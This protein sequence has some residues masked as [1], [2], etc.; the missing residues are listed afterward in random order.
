MLALL[1][2]AVSLGQEPAPPVLSHGP[3][4]GPNGP[5]S[6]S[7]WARADRPGEYRLE[8]THAADGS[9]T[10]WQAQ[11]E[12]RTDLTLHWQATGLPAGAAFTA[13]VYRGEQV[14]F[15]DRSWVLTTAPKEPAAAAV[16]AFGSCSNDKLFPEQP[17]WG[18]VLARAPQ[19]LV[20]LGD[21]P[22]IDLGTLPA[23]RQRFREFYALPSVRAALQTVPTW[24]TWDDHDFATNDAFGAAKGSDTA[25]QVFAEYHADARL[26]DGREGIYTSFR[27]GP[28]EVFLLDTRSFADTGPS[29]FA[30]EA[31]TLLGPAQSAWLQAGLRQSL[32]PFKVLACG[33]VWN[34]AVRPKKLDCWANWSD[35]RDALWR[36]L[37]S[38]GIGGVVLVSGDVHRSRVLRHA[39]HTSVGYELLEFVTSPLAQNPIA[40][41]A[42][43]VPG[44]EFDAAEPH[45]ALLLHAT[46][47]GAA[48]QLQA[49]FVAGDGREFHHR[50]V[51]RRDL[52][53]APR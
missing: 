18:Q 6:L 39:T 1:A 7:I 5:A 46:G 13:V 28:L 27:R 37:G 33:M 30:A 40:S 17:I 22:Y 23:R 14:V 53:P 35:E 32:A 45:S 25:R 16:V 48:A 34:G 43:E 41:N 36:W 49:T 19:A 52:E 31:R 10:N 29:P 2:V 12:L 8:L 9:A 4:R 15:A 42:V 51:L 3:L 24:A 38:A 20:L 26:G 44:L 47:H 21:T 11:A 50:T